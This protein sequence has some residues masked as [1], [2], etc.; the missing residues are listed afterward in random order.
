MKEI[1]SDIN[2]N[3]STGVAALALALSYV[4]IDRLLPGLQK[5]CSRGS[6]FSHHLLGAFMLSCCILIT[7][8]CSYC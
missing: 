7:K 8:V 6:S 2:V 5:L 3:Y 1:I 4:I